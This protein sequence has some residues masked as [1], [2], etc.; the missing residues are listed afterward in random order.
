MPRPCRQLTARRFAAVEC[1][2]HLGER[3]I[4][5]V[6]EEERRA[7]EGRETVEREQQRDRQ[8]LGELRLRIRG[9]RPRVD[10]GVRQPRSDALLAPGACRSQDVGAESVSWP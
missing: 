5:D 10:D 3:A 6:V 7:L 9:Q 2:G 4:E 1:P 8:I